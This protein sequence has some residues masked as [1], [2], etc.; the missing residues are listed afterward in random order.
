MKR[1]TSVIVRSSRRL[2]GTVAAA[3]V[4]AG[5]HV[6]A[7]GNG[8][9]A[10]SGDASG[11]L[12]HA[13]QTA[14]LYK[15]DGQALYRSADGG[16]RWTK[17]PL[18][19]LPE[20]ARITAV[21]VSA[22]AEGA[23]HAAGPG[24]GV[25]KSVDAGKTWAP[26]GAGLP[27]RD[28]VAFAVHATLPD[29]LYAVI[30]GEGIYRSEDGGGS[31]HM[32]DKGPKAPIRRL[33]HAD[34]E[35]SMQTG[36]LFAA[37]DQGVYRAMDCFCGF[38]LAGGLSDAAAA[39]AY[40]PKQPAALYAAVGQQVLSTEDGGEAW[41]PAGSP[42]GEVRALAHAPTGELYALL[43]DGRVMR[44]RDKGKQWE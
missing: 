39:I 30:G 15:S 13:P 37:T 9:L 16:R 32:V 27:S 19:G 5:L 1:M 40:D 18:A 25:L 38:R 12:A 26:V 36:W 4:V 33:I 24:A 41:R 31:W 8:A 21:A 44:S 29:T 17:L 6:A 10:G 2:A 22:G 7:V 34:M 43:A 28:V 11:A 42:G 3:L 35:G 20:D 23:L 14:A